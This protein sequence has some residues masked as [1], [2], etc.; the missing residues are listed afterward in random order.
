MENYQEKLP[1]GISLR[2]YSGSDLI[3]ENSG[4]WL[5]PLFAAEDF[6]NGEDYDD[7]RL[8]D[9]VSGTAAAFLAYRLGIEKVHADMVSTGALSVYE[10]FG[11]SIT[12]NVHVDRILCKTE[13]LFSPDSDPDEVYEELAVR[14]G[15]V[16]T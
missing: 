13:E 9:T 1:E 12:Y 16:R 15:C 14:A 8:H 10:R 3:F 11:I 2:L 4:Q 5:H 6:L 7:L